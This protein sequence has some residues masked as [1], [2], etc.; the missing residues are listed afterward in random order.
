[1]SVAFLNAVTKM[2]EQLI[3][4]RLNKNRDKELQE[5]GNSSDSS[6]SESEQTDG[7]CI[8]INTADFSLKPASLSS[9]DRSE[10]VRQLEK[11]GKL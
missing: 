3:N 11:L 5:A 1:V 2:E 9:S 4:E 7:R 8:V 10:V 6:C